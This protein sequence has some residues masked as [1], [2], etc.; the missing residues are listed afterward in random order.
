MLLLFPAHIGRE[1]S[2]LSL[3]RVSRSCGATDGACVRPRLRTSRPH[4]FSLNSICDVTLGWLLL[5][6]KLQVDIGR[7]L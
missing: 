6:A 4:S 2:L 3:S 7:L 5:H 1:I